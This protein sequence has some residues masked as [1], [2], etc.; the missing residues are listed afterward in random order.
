[1]LR[2]LFS[3]LIVFLYIYSIE[4]VS[5]P[6]ALGTRVFIGLIGA[7]VFVLRIRTSSWLLPIDSSVLTV[8]RPLA[9][10][11]MVSLLSIAI[12]STD[13]YEFLFKYQISIAL[14]FFAGYAVNFFIERFDNYG[15]KGMTLM[16][17]VIN[18]VLVQNLLALLMFFVSDL[19]SFLVSIQVVSDFEQ[20]VLDEQGAFRLVGFGSKF[21]GSGV[22]NGYALL[23]IGYILRFTSQSRKQR[24]IYVLKYLAILVLG[25][26]MA[27]TTMVGAL[28]SVIIMFWPVHG[29]KEVLI[30]LRLFRQIAL[31]FVSLLLLVLVAIWV[32]PSIVDTFEILF[33]FGF[34]MVWNYLDGNSLAT[35]STSELLEMYKW[36]SSYLTYFIGDGWYFDPNDSSYYMQ[37]D[38]GILRLVFYY[39]IPGLMLF[40]IFQ[41]RVLM[42]SFSALKQGS[43]LIALFFVYFLILSLKG[44]SDLFFLNV[45]F[46]FQNV[47]S[48]L[49]EKENIV[50]NGF[51]AK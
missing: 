5:V 32:N 49:N 25:M 37:T 4:F 9:F 11:S 15:P 28:L 35:N 14:I 8:F 12:N 10:I 13:D 16:S 19:R 24:N 22:V 7:V 20:S 41:F 50:C 36:P 30:A 48:A 40:C 44:F 33:N 17:L 31:I 47:K 3:F 46:Y 34:E 26:M 18:V 21:F 43:T 39:G 27:R 6:F 1:M 38:V 42:L 23:L 29:L 2:G 51:Q 45:L